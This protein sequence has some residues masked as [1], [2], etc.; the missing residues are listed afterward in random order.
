[1]REIEFREGNTENDRHSTGSLGVT[2][3]NLRADNSMLGE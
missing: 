2:E 3:G 1:M